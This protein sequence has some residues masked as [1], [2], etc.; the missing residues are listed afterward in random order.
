MNQ[1]FSD[2]RKKNNE[3]PKLFFHDHIF[4]LSL[5]FT[6][7]QISMC[8]LPRVVV[9]WSA[10][11]FYPSPLTRCMTIFC[12]RLL[13]N[14]I[15]PHNLSPVISSADRRIIDG[16]LILALNCCISPC[17]PLSGYLT[18]EFFLYTIFFFIV[19]PTSTNVFVKI[20]NECAVLYFQTGWITCAYTKNRI[21][22]SLVSFF[23]LMDSSGFDGKHQNPPGIHRNVI[24]N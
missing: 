5:F 16:Y 11:F 9:L 12:V 13:W 24:K 3:V 19:V 23:R 21:F 2:T 7:N 10:I 18:S 4:F 1:P 14:S 20:N 8:I 17:F 6:N 15:F 22:K